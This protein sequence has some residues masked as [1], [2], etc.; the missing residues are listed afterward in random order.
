M[1]HAVPSHASMSVWATPELL[2]YAPT[3]QHCDLDTHVTPFKSECALITGE[4]TTTHAL[5]ASALGDPPITAALA[6]TTAKH[7]RQIRRLNAVTRK[8]LTGRLPSAEAS[9]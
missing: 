7:T 3:A 5:S 9:P 1:D 4:R 6:K 8:R 2:R